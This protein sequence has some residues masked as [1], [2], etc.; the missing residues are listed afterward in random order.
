MKKALMALV[1]A[2]ALV[3]LASCVST[4]PLAGATGKVGSR[5]G[6]STVTSILGFPYSGDAGIV[7]AAKNGGISTVGTVDVKVNWMVFTTTITT[8]VT[9]E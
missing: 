7:A 4:Y 6:T 9:G 3:L 8:V 2:L 1:V 5:V